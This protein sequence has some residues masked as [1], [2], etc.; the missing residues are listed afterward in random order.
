MWSAGN[1]MLG[2]VSLDARIILNTLIVLDELGRD[3]IGQVGRHMIK[4][5]GLKVP[6]PH[7]HLE[8]RDC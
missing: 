7:E 3:A 4:D 8:I 5:S 6:D 2:V 1:T